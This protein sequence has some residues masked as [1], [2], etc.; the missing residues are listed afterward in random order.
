V[1]LVGLVVADERAQVGRQRG[2]IGADD[3]EQTASRGRR[4]RREEAGHQVAQ[5]ERRLRVRQGKRCGGAQPLVDLGPDPDRPCD[6]LRR[7]RQ[8]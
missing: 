6:R 4:A 1:V 8:R 3:P 2:A 5:R 7:A